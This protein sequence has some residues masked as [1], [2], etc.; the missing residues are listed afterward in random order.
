MLLQVIASRYYCN[1]NFDSLQLGMST[2]NHIRE[3]I[4]RL[5]RLGASETWG[6][7]LNPA[8]MAALGYLSRANRFSRSPSHVADYLG[9]TRGTMSQTLKALVRKGYVAE[10]RSATDKRSISYGLT[11]DGRAFVAKSDAFDNA[12]AALPAIEKAQL[13]GALSSVLMALIAE[14]GGK[15]FGVCATCR[16]HK[17]VNAGLYC[18]LLGVPLTPVDATHICQ[19]YAP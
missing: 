15:V 7:D 19:E 2:P 16:H 10:Q 18:E 3:L 5:A 6:D 4:T 9:T 11:D 17:R 1:H 13:D 12:I 8:Q 14:N